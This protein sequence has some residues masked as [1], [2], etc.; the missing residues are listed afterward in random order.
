[1]EFS[2]QEHWSGLPFP[3]PGNSLYVFLKLRYY[4]HNLRCP[5]KMYSLEGFVLV[6]LFFGEAVFV[7]NKKGFLFTG[8]LEKDG[9]WYGFGQMTLGSMP[10]RF[11]RPF[12]LPYLTA[13]RILVPN[14]GL[15]PG[16]V[17]ESRVLTT[18]Q[19]GNS[20][21][22]HFF[23]IAARWLLWLQASCSHSR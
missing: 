1:M 10:L 2:G 18:R 7:L 16:Q 12:F 5:F 13:C 4:S 15:N 3:S 11:S 14:Q 9:C 8:I 23:L 22:W 17:S 20:L 6:G 21:S 19:P